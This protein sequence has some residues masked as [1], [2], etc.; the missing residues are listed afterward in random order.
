MLEVL[1]Q[2][3]EEHK[4]RISRNSGCY[5]YPA[6]F[7]LIA[8]MNPCPCGNYPD[9]NKCNCTKTQIQNYLGHVSQPFLDRMDLCVEASRV[10]YGELHK[11]GKEE[12]GD[13]FID[14]GGAQEILPQKYGGA[15][16]H[17]P[18]KGTVCGHASPEE[19]EQHERPKGCPKPCPGVGDDI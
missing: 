13:D 7:M 6:D 12:T 17:N 2:P 11:T 18:G 5:E 15:A 9:L 8:A 3:L 1:R 4:I 16:H 19:G 14:A 10:E